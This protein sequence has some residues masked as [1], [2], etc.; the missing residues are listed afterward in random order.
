MWGSLRHA[1]TGF[2][3]A[4]W[5]IQEDGL[6]EIT[7]YRAVSNPWLALSACLLV[8]W[9]KPEER[10]TWALSAVQNFFHTSDM[11]CGPVPSG[12]LCSQMIWS[13]SNW[14]VSKAEGSLERATK[15][16]ALEKC[17][18][19][20]NMR[21]RKCSE[22]WARGLILRA[23]IFIKIGHLK[24]HCKIS[25]NVGD[26]RYC[27]PTWDTISTPIYTAMMNTEPRMTKD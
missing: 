19:Q 8:W 25:G 17:K 16:T 3:K 20:G 7:H 5:E 12:M 24:N 23:E 18:I 15:W 9:W 26:T 11:N 2:T 22:Q 13:V 4:C 6:D 1:E 10:L 27:T 21:P 14:A